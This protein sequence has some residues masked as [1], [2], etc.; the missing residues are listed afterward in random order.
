M[1]H[2]SY[3]KLSSLLLL[4][5]FITCKIPTNVHASL[6]V[7][8]ASLTVQ[9]ETAPLDLGVAQDLTGLTGR[10]SRLL[11]VD[12]SESVEPSTTAR[13]E[14][15][16]AEQDPYVDVDAS[17]GR[18]RLHTKIDLEQ[19]C[20]RAFNCLHGVGRHKFAVLVRPHVADR[21]KIRQP[22]IARLQFTLNVTDWNDHAPEFPSIDG[23]YFDIGCDESIC[24][25]VPMPCSSRKISLPVATDGDF[26]EE[27][28][29]ISYSFDPASLSKETAATFTLKTDNI[30][31]PYLF[32]QKGL[33]AETRQYYQFDLL[34]RD[35]PGR[36]G[37]ARVRLTIK[38]VN[39]NSPRFRNKFYNVSV[40]ENQPNGTLILQLTADDLDLH[41]NLSYSLDPTEASEDV[42]RH[43]RV[44]DDGGLLTT[45]EPLDYEKINELRFSVRVFDGN[46]DDTAPVHLR[47]LDRN[48]NPPRYRESDTK[49]FYVTENE[50]PGDASPR[51]VSVS[52]P[53]TGPGGQWTCRGAANSEQAALQFTSVEFSGVYKIAI[54][55][56]IDREVEP[57]VTG[58]LTCWDAGD[59]SLT[60]TYTAL[61]QVTDINDNAPVFKDADHYGCI[62]AQVEENRRPGVEVVNVKA[63]DADKGENARITY[64]LISSSSEVPFAVD[65]TSG[66]LT[67]TS[68]L[69]RESVDKYELLVEAADAGNPAMST[70]A[71]VKV[72]ILDTNDH[73]PEFYGARHFSIV[74][75]SE[76]L[77]QLGQLTA[78]DADLGENAQVTFTLLSSPTASSFR[79]DQ[80][81][82]LYTLVSFDREEC[83]K[84]RLR[85]RATDQGPGGLA[86]HTD[87]EVVVTIIDE[88]DEP[89]RISLPAEN[90]TSVRI[91]IYTHPKNAL[92]IRV[93][94]FDPDVGANARMV[95]KLIAPETFPPRFSIDSSSGDIRV[96]GEL[97]I[98]DL[99]RHTVIA[100]VVGGGRH[101]WS[102]IRV[103]YIDVDNSLPIASDET[104]AS[105]TE[106]HTR[107]NVVII[108]TLASVSA[109]LAV[110]LILAVACINRSC[111]GGLFDLAYRA[112]RGGRDGGRGVGGVASIGGRKKGADDEDQRYYEQETPL[113][114][115]SCDVG[116]H[117]SH[118]CST[119]GCGGRPFIVQ[120]MA[121]LYRHRQ[122]I[123][124]SSGTATGSS[125]SSGAA[126]ATAGPGADG[127]RSDSGRGCSDEDLSCALCPSAAA[128][129]AAS[130]SRQ[131]NLQALHPLLH[132][133]HHHLHQQQLQQHQQQQQSSFL[134]QGIGLPSP[135]SALPESIELGGIGSSGGGS[136]L[137]MPASP[138]PT[139]RSCL[140]PR[141]IYPEGSV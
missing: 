57:S 12:S 82:S 81:G 76:A 106:R 130:M 126:A 7:L 105:L 66:R 46:F 68:L 6:T 54:Q 109:L 141:I 119:M 127:N 88:D 75:N 72:S 99:R 135:M 67:T 23:E 120:D 93:R 100:K 55:R 90:G 21:R 98:V 139:D 104:A 133:Q 26:S 35:G 11:A 70:T 84:H 86:R 83:P 3:L 61:V 34:A 92:V 140:A 4:A 97:G 115:A 63:T 44:T 80:D 137:A 64:R 79:L 112:G 14:Y 94:A 36:E 27:F 114:E 25:V 45:E 2:L 42:R 87:A 48:D 37:R 89:P 121:S 51:F 60:S 65:P 18:L 31:K 132:H 69:D 91:S 16:M 8:S 40:P 43:L 95:Y 49:P 13:A 77:I 113:T 96:A 29:S 62:A 53:D 15:S 78:R 41:Y 131:S 128:A 33:D 56:A 101:T 50:L 58:T 125:A 118:L 1:P 28:R 32:I 108:I 136:S 38:D 39:D 9:E 59:P 123:P 138:Q 124:A 74:E 110:A 19:L 73:A 17:T 129:A 47:V 10:L 52:D 122:A 111:T 107:R 22:I 117:H 85:V 24:F 20:V 134:S 71:T 102:D 30:D 5:A 103:I 116:S